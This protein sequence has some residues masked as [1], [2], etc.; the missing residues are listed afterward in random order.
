M[1]QRSRQPALFPDSASVAPVGPAPISEAVRTRAR[2][3]LP[4]IHLGTSS[5]S[6]PGS[7]GSV[8]DRP[9][10]REVLARHGLAAS[11]RHPLLRAVGIDRTCYD[12]PLRASQLRDYAAAVPVALAGRIAQGGV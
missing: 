6:F 11:A 9:A 1:P 8:Y 2:A 10:R 5:W 12:A 7:V 4:A 3:L